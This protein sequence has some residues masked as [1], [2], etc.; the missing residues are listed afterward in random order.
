MVKNSSSRVLIVEDQPVVADALRQLIDGEQDMSVVGVAGSVAESTS[1]AE[2]LR[3]D[4]VVMDFRL[5]DGNGA[6]AGST[7]HRTQPQAKLVFLS[8]DDTLSARLAA[9][10]VGARAFINKS[11]A[12]FKLI[13]ALRFV[14]R[15]KSL[16]DPP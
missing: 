5:P 13:D 14:A 9:F 12:A 16:M 4:I 15:G 2:E 10:N 6:D 1:Q 8:R 11:N 3:P 7:I